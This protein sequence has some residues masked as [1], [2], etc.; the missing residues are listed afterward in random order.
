MTDSDILSAD[1]GFVPLGWIG[2][3]VFADTNRNGIRDAGE[4]GIEGVVVDLFDAGGALFDSVSTA[5]DGSYGFSGVPAGDYSVVARAPAGMSATVDGPNQSAED[6]AKAM[7]F[8]VTVSDGGASTQADFGFVAWSRVGDFVF[9]DVDGD[10]E[11][12]AGDSPLGGVVVS[13]HDAG[14]DLVAT[15]VSAADGAYGFDAVRP[16][17]YTVE[18]VIPADHALSDPTGSDS[19][20]NPYA[21]TVTDSD[22]LSADFGFVPLEPSIALDKAL[23]GAL[24]SAVSDTQGH[25]D[26][27][28]VF[29]L[30]NTGDVDLDGLSLVDD[31][32]A[33]FNGG[34]V[35]VVEPPV[36]GAPGQF[37]GDGSWGRAPDWLTGELSGS[38]VYTGVAPHTDLLRGAG[39]ALSDAD[40]LAPGE[41]MEVA[42]SIEIDPRAAVSLG[43]VPLANQAE[44]SAEAVTGT[45]GPVSDLSDSGLNPANS[46]EGQ[47]FEVTG[48]RDDPTRTLIPRIEL[49]L[50]VLNP[51]E[52]TVNATDDTWVDV[53]FEFNIDNNGS[54]PLSHVSVTHDLE[55]VMGLGSVQTEAGARTGELSDVI[56]SGSGES[57]LTLNPAWDATAASPELVE[58]SA[59]HLNTL[60]PGDRCRFTA[61]VTLSPSEVD[62]ILS[63]E[64]IATASAHADAD[65]DGVPDAIDRRPYDPTDVR[66]SGALGA[67]DTA[68]DSDSGFDPDTINADAINHGSAV[69]EGPDDDG[70][71]L[72]DDPT[73]V[74]LSQLG[75]A[76][77]VLTIYPDAASGRV[78]NLDVA[79]VFTVV[80]GGNVPVSDLHL[81]E[82][83]AANLDAAFITTSTDVRASAGI[84]ARVEVGPAGQWTGRSDWV[85]AAAPAFVAG[86]VPGHSGFTGRGALSLAE[87]DLLQGGSSS[88]TAT[89]TLAPGSGFEVRVVVELDPDRATG[90]SFYPLMNQGRL[91]AQRIDGAV[92]EAYSDFGADPTS[93]NDGKD[94]GET[95]GSRSDAT[96]LFLAD[97]ALT[98]DI[99]SF[100]ANAVNSGWIDATLTFAVANIG[101]SDLYNL[102]VR[103]AIE[104]QLG[105]GSVVPSTVAGS[106]TGAVGQPVECLMQG[107]GRQAGLFALNSAF[108]GTAAADE[109]IDQTRD[110]FLPIGETCRFSIIVTMVPALIAANPA[111]NQAQA[112]GYADSDGDGVP[113][114]D[115]PLN[116]RFD[117]SVS[118]FLGASPSDPVRDFSDAGLDPKSINA[119]HP[120]HASPDAVD[121]P[122]R[123]TR[124]DN[125][126]PTALSFGHLALSKAV[127]EQTGATDG[128][129][130]IVEFSFVVLNDG[131]VP[132]H[133]LNL[134]DSLDENLGGAFVAVQGAPMIQPLD[135]VS[136]DQIFAGIRYETPD[137]VGAGMGGHAGF[138]GAGTGASLD[139]L[140]LD[141]T[142]V[143]APKE[144]FVVTLEAMLDPDGAVG[145]LYNPVLENQAVVTGRDT[146]TNA[147]VQDASASGLDPTNGSTSSGDPANPDDG[148]TPI[149]LPQATLSKTARSLIDL[150]PDPDDPADSTR[151]L[152]RAGFTYVVENTGSAALVGLNL[153]DDFLLQN[154][155]PTLSR[156]V[157]VSSVGEPETLGF[158]HSGVG[159]SADDFD[160]V[161]TGFLSDG[162][163][164]ALG[165]STDGAD[166]LAVGESITVTIEASFVIDLAA[167]ANL[168]SGERL[169]NS[170]LVTAYADSDGDGIADYHD[171]TPLSANPGDVA[172]GAADPG[173]DASDLSDGDGLADADV[174]G[175]GGTTEDNPTPV[176]FADLQVTKTVIGYEQ[177]GHIADVHFLIVAQNAG[178]VSLSRL[179]IIE[180]LQADFGP[181]FDSTFVPARVELSSYTNPAGMT[182]TGGS[183]AAEIGLSANTATF[184]GDPASGAWLV[185]A[186]APGWATS[187]LPAG[188]VVRFIVTAPLNTFVQPDFA[189]VNHALGQATDPFSPASAPR[190]TDQSDNGSETDDEATDPD[191]DPTNDPTTV[192]GIIAFKSLEAV[193]QNAAEPTYLDATYRLI[194]LNAGSVDLVDVRLEDDFSAQLGSAFIDAAGGGVDPG[195]S[196]RVLDTLSVA[197]LPVAF[198]ALSLQAG[199]QAERGFDGA[200]S[201]ALLQPGFNLP[202][203]RFV[204]VEVT[205]TLNP[206]AAPLDALGQPQTLFN[207]GAAQ[208][209]LDA[210]GDGVADLADRAG[211]GTR[212]GP[213]LVRDAVSDDITGNPDTP[214]EPGSPTPLTQP[215]IGVSKTVVNLSLDTETQMLT[216]VFE[217]KIENLGALTLHDLHLSDDQVALLALDAA[218]S[219]MTVLGATA[220]DPIRL[221]SFVVEQPLS[222]VCVGGVWGFQ[223]GYDGGL[224]EAQVLAISGGSTPAT[225]GNCLAPGDAVTLSYALHYDF[226]G[227]GDA[228]AVTFGNKAVA[229]GLIDANRDDVF[230]AAAVVDESTN[231]TDPDGGDD[232]VGAGDVDPLTQDNGRPS[233]SDDGVPNEDDPTPAALPV[234]DV[235][236]ELVATASIED[237]D[238]VRLTWKFDLINQGNVP[239]YDFGLVDDLRCV[240]GD[241]FIG[242]EIPL[243]EVAGYRPGGLGSFGSK[244]NAGYRGASTLTPCSATPSV[245]QRGTSADLLDG[246]GVL[247]PGDALQ[248]LLTA[249]LDPE[250]PDFANEN[251]VL[252]LYKHRLAAYDVADPASEVLLLDRGAEPGDGGRTGGTPS[253]GVVLTKYLLAVT[254][255][256]EP[257]MPPQALDAQYR[258]RVE[259]TGSSAIANLSV[260]DEALPGFGFGFLRATVNPTLT[261]M[262]ADGSSFALI[263]TGYTGMTGTGAELL[264]RDAAGLD[265]Q[266]TSSLLMPGDAFAL[267]ITVTFDPDQVL[268]DPFQTDPSGRIAIVSNAA[269]IEAALD[270]DG[271]VMTGPEKVDHDANPATPDQVV[272]VQDQSDDIHP[273]DLDGDGIPN[274]DFEDNGALRDDP[275]AT[276]VP[277]LSVALGQRGL[278]VPYSGITPSGLDCTTATDE[279]FCYELVFEVFVTN[280]G[281]SNLTNLQLVN[282]LEAQFVLAGLEPEPTGPADAFLGARVSELRFFNASSAGSDLSQTPT[283]NAGFNGFAAGSGADRAGVG[284]PNLFVSLI[285]PATPVGEQGLLEPGDRV[286][287]VITAYVDPFIQSVTAIGGSMTPLTNAV[288][289]YGYTDSDRDGSPDAVDDNTGLEGPGDQPNPAMVDPTVEDLSDNDSDL[290]GMGE[291]TDDAPGD[292]DGDGDPTND[293]ATPMAFPGLKVVK[294]LT[295]VEMLDNSQNYRATFAVKVTNVGTIALEDLVVSDNLTNA[296]GSAFV[297]VLDAP[298]LV[299]AES[300]IS[301]ASR[302]SADWLNPLYDGGDLAAPGAPIYEQ[303]L[304]VSSGRA[305]LASGDF[306]TLTYSVEIDF[307]AND[308]SS[309]YAVP[310][311]PL[312]HLDRFTNSATASALPVLG[313]ATAARIQDRSDNDADRDGR[314]DGDNDGDAT[315]DDDPTPAPGLL[316]EKSVVSAVVPSTASAIEQLAGMGSKGPSGLIAPVVANTGTQNTFLARFRF[317]WINTGGLPLYGLDLDDQMA[318]QPGIKRILQAA[319]V[320]GSMQSSQADSR[321]TDATALWSGRFGVAMNAFD[322]DPGTTAFYA[323]GNALG[324]CERVTFEIDVEFEIDPLQS[325]GWSNAAVTTF[326]VDLDADGVAD[327][328]LRDYSDG[329]GDPLR[330]SDPSGA[331]PGADPGDDPTQVPLAR[332]ALAKAF[333][334]DPTPVSGMV[335]FFDHRVQIRV[336]NI[337]DVPLTGLRL[338]DDD[339]WNEW[340]DVAAAK[341][342]PYAPYDGAAIVGR[343]VLVSQSHPE[344]GSLAAALSASHSASNT[345][346]QTAKP[347]WVGGALEDSDTRVMLLSGAQLAVGE[348]F[349]LQFVVRFNPFAF[350]LPLEGYLANQ[351]QALAEEAD[352]ASPDT[353]LFPGLFTFDLS[354]SG[355]DPRSDNPSAP[356]REGESNTFE[357]PTP[358]PNPAAPSVRVTKRAS[359]ETVQLGDFATWELTVDNLSVIP[360]T[361]ISLVDVL[362]AGLVPL[363]STYQVDSSEASTGT[364]PALQLLEAG[365][366]PVPAGLQNI[367]IGDVTVTNRGPVLLFEDMDLNP[368]DRVVL[369]FQTQATIALSVGTYINQAYALDDKWE[370][371]NQVVSSTVAEAALSVRPTSIFDCATIVGQ[372]FD[373]RDGDGYARLSDEGIPSARIST[374]VGGTALEIRTDKYGRYHLPC[375]VIPN[376]DRGT[377]V[378]LKLDPRSLPTGHRVTSENPRVIRVSRGKMTEANFGVSSERVVTL[379]LNTCAFAG[380]SNRLTR[381]SMAGVV[382]LVA[383][384][385][386]GQSRLRISYRAH[387]ELENLIRQRKNLLKQQVAALWKRSGRPYRLEVEFETV[388]SIGTP[389]PTCQTR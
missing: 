126:D 278:A 222:G 261:Q 150:G 1:F 147:L 254:S 53:V 197:E 277:D 186:S 39:S 325:S 2:D 131:N 205:V 231:G 56:C 255:N 139:L 304:L 91:T 132:L 59:P 211:D 181:A 305:E 172:T 360:A 312:T 240:Y 219:G 21:I 167:K 333:L 295:G 50:A 198:A 215:S 298:S 362:P 315:N 29:T 144:G 96:P 63:N 201:K 204:G 41:G 145:V 324:L 351:A 301:D 65:A 90:R 189:G 242:A 94:R 253:G 342:G 20:A 168:L 108:E 289:G 124:A 262:P 206:I 142:Q 317:D 67:V 354:D 318:R 260:I 223:S 280:T 140:G 72:N 373:D 121:G 113:D 87:T 175:T 38:R 25:Y 356:R 23:I 42:L 98:K 372:V 227:L 104:G 117:P 74:R 336:E 170:G 252:G 122:D 367:T 234:L 5:G 371:A 306:V 55:A 118:A 169:T 385:K 364:V 267:D 256:D 73:P 269:R 57:N 149:I 133:Q 34:L 331:G 135:R 58:Q 11:Y 70:S 157:V 182:L 110:A 293:D 291:P 363:V 349:T 62:R 66:E 263:N 105:V 136:A 32:G 369:S 4:P 187:S 290:D 64:T 199:A 247:S 51:L 375:S 214:R 339:F 155:S 192:P 382:S 243:V 326:G 161:G 288:T 314:G 245:A 24:V 275:V 194:A 33:Q 241:A 134:T 388:T 332:L 6:H 266:P 146:R 115:E 177:G 195:A 116:A 112:R 14:G 294:A 185:D 164:V 37:S 322:Q 389:P 128:D 270:A 359:P 258:L 107:V 286:R 221:T 163:A 141:G 77:D 218:A 48:R 200:G 184:T 344:N 346:G 158:A 153:S 273:S 176:G 287:A 302:I 319:F 353:A 152:V 257:G 244:V 264:L 43:R 100:A 15:T 203:E 93:T 193:R 36:M 320:D 45:L 249:T 328:Q 109:L 209:Y 68:D 17:S 303:E 381:R 9:R 188:G 3:Q 296:F 329:D 103:D 174:H 292:S 156:T 274:D 229:S 337:G 207:Q 95:P 237:S 300:Q 239:V 282:D 92:L 123:D 283:L 338:I 151:R 285:D 316:T 335:P 49:T 71:D 358:L 79:Y 8:A 154:Q 217:V 191:L 383:K 75:V 323:S 12:E 166:R 180:D 250:H 307:D 143:L 78:G 226:A 265:A 99:A 31:L 334:P 368:G 179:Q 370:G 7:P 281:S 238:F 321:C 83:F 384:L 162:T 173:P 230:D 26:A 350:E 119:G 310:F 127:T 378:V 88:I 352:P 233:R 138:T 380:A 101:G 366:Y 376:E 327:A 28:F 387:D 52:T 106:R 341:P 160:A 210:N 171:P 236:K 130:V 365:D 22:I 213:V 13:L 85:D 10:G 19:Q 309:R 47:P 377:S 84:G 248:V 228:R 16:G 308:L 212:S 137:W 40:S 111:L 345:L 69:N 386:E 330:D 235:T 225:A 81:Y 220:G 114:Y 357:N 251:R 86:I 165:G 61:W 299:T 271:N 361:D 272:M 30:L 120:D 97:I 374:L 208:G 80:N 232:G 46:D 343:P 60:R 76:K 129:N 44:V 89:S 216:Q 276:L 125:D 148:T 246:H 102:S 183:A 279:G 355:F 178:D 18:V 347:S 297:Q 379:S 224:S 159:G 35:G 340:Y 284:D 348:S 313:L 311:D 196:I 202:P 190:V 82:H 27:T 54:V 268:A 259:N